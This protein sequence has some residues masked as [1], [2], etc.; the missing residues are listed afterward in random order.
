[1]TELQNVAYATQGHV[2]TIRIDRESA[3]NAMDTAT[4][5]GIRAAQKK[6]EA[7]PKVRI[8]VLTGT[9][10]AFS[11]GTDLKELPEFNTRH[12][13]FDISVRDYKPIIDGI[14]QSDMIYIAAINGVAGGIGLS[15]A[16]SCDLAIMSDKASCFAPFSNIGLVPDGGLSWLLLLHMGS[17]RAFE[18]IAEATHI[19]AK[20]CLEMGLVNRVVAEGELAGEAANWA[21]S[22]AER[23]PLSLAYSKRILRAAQTQSHAQTALLESEYQGMCANSEDSKA[24]VAAFV[25]KTKPVFKGR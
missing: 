7:D 17:K 25:A 16:L 1:M 15:V 12:G 18:A 19:S 6:A 20:D 23:A 5:A 21:A 3:M 10:R 24:A 13:M 2:A 11:S 22:L 14:T 9:G 8:V 4:R